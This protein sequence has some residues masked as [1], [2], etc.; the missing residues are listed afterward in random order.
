MMISTGSSITMNTRR[1]LITLSKNLGEVVGVFDSLFPQLG[2]KGKLHLIG[3]LCH[4][5]QLEEITRYNNL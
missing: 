3:T 5:R 2:F 4:W 1:T